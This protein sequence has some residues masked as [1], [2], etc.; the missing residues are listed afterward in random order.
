[1]R[2]LTDQVLDH[3]VEILGVRARACVLELVWVEFRTLAGGRVQEL[4]L[5]EVDEDDPAVDREHDVARVHVLIAQGFC[6]NVL[7]GHQ[8]LKGETNDG[9]LAKVG[10]RDLFQR[11]SG[12]IVR[13]Y[14]HARACMAR[15]GARTSR[16]LTKSFSL[17]TY[18]SRSFRMFG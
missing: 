14:L 11:L 12:N 4:A 9:R 16:P 1:M 5:A 17:Y 3:K 10:G 15:G 2:R 18:A 6:A 7:E 8:Q 13:K